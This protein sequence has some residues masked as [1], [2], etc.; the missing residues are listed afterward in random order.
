MAEVSF[1]LV[2]FLEGL[3][4][5]RG[6]PGRRDG[7]GVGGRRAGES[8]QRNNSQ[9]VSSS[10]L[11]CHHLAKVA[12]KQKL[13]RHARRARVMLLAGLVTG[14]LVTKMTHLSLL[15]GLIK[16]ENLLTH[17]LVRH[18]VA[19]LVGKLLAC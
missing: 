8:A 11:M 12:L 14:S 17:C 1:A 2:A 16:K 10:E 18:F 7:I 19:C 6:P 15:V 9:R 13:E 5:G 4:G 3:I